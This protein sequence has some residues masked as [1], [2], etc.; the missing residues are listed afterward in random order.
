MDKL[1]YFANNVNINIYKIM[2]LIILVQ[3][4]ILN[5]FNI[6]KHIFIVT[7]KKINYNY[8]IKHV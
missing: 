7:V 8:K 1:E 5:V 2:I 6:I 3:K 4:L